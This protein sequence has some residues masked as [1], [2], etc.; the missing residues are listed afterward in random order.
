MGTGI[1]SGNREIGKIFFTAQASYSDFRICPL[2]RLVPTPQAELC[3][4]DRPDYILIRSGTGR[5]LRQLPGLPARPP[6]ATGIRLLAGKTC[7]S[8][9]M[10]ILPGL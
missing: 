3:H 10:P 7:R 1:E 5:S 2:D 8:Q 4:D 9:V 6:T